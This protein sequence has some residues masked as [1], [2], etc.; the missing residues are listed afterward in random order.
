MAA[1]E[2]AERI[3]VD[4]VEAVDAAATPSKRWPRKTLTRRRPAGRCRDRGRGR[5]RSGCGGRGRRRR[6]SGRRDRDRRRRGGAE[7]AKAAES[8]AELVLADDEMPLERVG[9]AEIR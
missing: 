6:L 2:V 7:H 8:V 3:E 1:E 9:E 4:A 5:P